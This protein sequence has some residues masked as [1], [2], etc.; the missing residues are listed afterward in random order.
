MALYH[1]SGQAK[2]D[3]AQMLASQNAALQSGIETALTAYVSATDPSTGAS[4]AW[5]SAEVGRRWYDTGVDGSAQNPVLKVWAQLTTAPTYGWRLLRT[6][7]VKMLTAPAAIALATASPT[8]VNVTWT[9]KDFTADLDAAGAQ[10]NDDMLVVAVYLNIRAKEGGT[11]RVV[12]DADFDDLGGDNTIGGFHWREKG[13]TVEELLIPQVTDVPVE[14]V[15]RV[16]L[17]ANEIAQ[18]AL[19]VGSTSPDLH[20]RAKLV[21][22]EEW[23]V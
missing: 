6:R 3:F 20:F 17:D 1:T 14:R 2:I 10:D 19:V 8:A 22:F 4:P 21:G 5:G 11:I 9:D 23:S 7:A 13:S 18:Y 15:I 16:E 12:A